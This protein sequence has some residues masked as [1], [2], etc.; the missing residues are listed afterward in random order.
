MK[1]VLKEKILRIKSF[2][3][4]KEKRCGKLQRKHADD[5]VTQ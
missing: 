4:N 3:V 5:D 2:M 1:K